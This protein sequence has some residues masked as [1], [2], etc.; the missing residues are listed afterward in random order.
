[1]NTLSRAEMTTEFSIKLYN[2]PP[3]RKDY[4]I[5][6]SSIFSGN[7]R[8]PITDFAGNRSKLILP[9]LLSGNRVTNISGNPCSSPRHIASD[10]AKLSSNSME[11]IPQKLFPVTMLPMFPVPSDTKLLL[12]KNHSE[13]I[14]FE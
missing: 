11:L 5:N 8:F 2:Y 4:Q 13:I 9:E 1:M 6:S 14:I 3:R 10:P 12:T 7:H